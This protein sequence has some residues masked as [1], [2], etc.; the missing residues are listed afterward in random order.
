MHSNS[1]VALS[2]GDRR[3]L[4][5]RLRS[6]SA[7][8]DD[9]RRARLIVMLADGETFDAV[10][11]ELDCS[12]TYITRW[13]SR[14]LEGG[15]ASLYPRYRGRKV[16]ALTAAMEAR[17]LAA[18]KRKPDDG[19]T[20][21]STR[22]LAEKLGISHMLVHRAW[23]RAGIKPHRIKRY[24]RSNDPEFE[25]KAADVIGLYL[26]PPQHAAVFC[27]DEKTAIQALDRLDPVLPLSPGRLERHGF[28]YYRHGTLSLFAALNT[29]T[30]TVLGQ[31]VDRHS[32]A[33]FVAFLGAIVASQPRGKEIHVI[34]DNLSAHKTHRVDDFLADHPNVSLHFTPTYSSW[35]N[36][37]EIWFSKIER[38]VISRGVFT[39]VNDLAR[40]LMRYIRLY[41]R[42]PK[43]IKWTYS[44]PS[45]RIRGIASSVTSH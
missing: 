43:P 8:A 37:V 31:T 17:I 7:R 27:V 44:D 3:E 36:Q 16:T 12:R 14:F 42:R 40:K 41:N 1:T 4:E 39:S 2:R 30:G 18:T 32:S 26:N 6:R 10:Q 23:V 45:H 19:S 34:L 28:E 9:V 21:W 35:L 20:H 38:H 11:Q 24:M 15:L 25:K 22:R 13:K 29:R 33:E 5:A